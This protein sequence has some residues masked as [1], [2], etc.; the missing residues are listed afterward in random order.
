M[1]FFYVS[2]CTEALCEE[3]VQLLVYGMLVCVSEDTDPSCQTEYVWSTILRSILRS[4][5]VQS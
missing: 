1:F 4:I 3:V 5:G 2:W